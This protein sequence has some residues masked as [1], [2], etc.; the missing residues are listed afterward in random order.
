MALKSTT[1]Q[2]Q[3]HT[4]LDTARQVQQRTARTNAKRTSNQSRH[5]A[6]SS[7]A[8]H[9]A[10]QARTESQTSAQVEAQEVDETNEQVSLPAT[11][12]S[13][14]EG[15]TRTSKLAFNIGA[16]VTLR[17]RLTRSAGAPAPV[18]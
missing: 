14:Q 4:G 12:V 15:G 13:T 7:S 18:T 16:K 2:T 3:T 1:D 9:K 11:V 17:F 6:R 10:Q 8:E 5:S